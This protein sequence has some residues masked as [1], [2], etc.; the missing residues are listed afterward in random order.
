MLSISKLLFQRKRRN[1]LPSETGQN[2]AVWSPGEEGLAFTR[3]GGGSS[4][5]IAFSH[6]LSRLPWRE[7]TNL[8]EAGRDWLGCGHSWKPPRARTLNSPQILHSSS[9]H[10]PFAVAIPSSSSSHLEGLHRPC[11]NNELLSRGQ[12]LCLGCKVVARI[13][14]ASNLKFYTSPWRS[15]CPNLHTQRLQEEKLSLGLLLSTNHSTKEV[16][17]YLALTLLK[18]QV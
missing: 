13:V 8:I 1:S 14:L 15:K 2:R 4:F 18:L 6:R 12:E 11:T 5:M 17:K 3:W 7:S 16:F 9:P 10:L